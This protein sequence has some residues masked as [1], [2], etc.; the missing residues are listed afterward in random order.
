MLQLNGERHMFG[1]VV[2]KQV[3]GAA[4][5]V[6]SAD[7]SIIFS[8]ASVNLPCFGFTQ[9]AKLWKMWHFLYHL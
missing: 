7:Y 8:S 6:R 1:H 9:M 3:R 5:E 4:V 2:S